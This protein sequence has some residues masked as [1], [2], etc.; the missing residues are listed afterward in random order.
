[1]TAMNP[2]LPPASATLEAPGW[3]INRTN[4]G[5]TYY[6]VRDDGKT[7][8]GNMQERYSGSKAAAVAALQATAGVTTAE[9][10]RIAGMNA[11]G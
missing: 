10:A 7:F 4:Q 5:T 6:V 3:A 1:M 11:A 2:Q 9:L 8:L